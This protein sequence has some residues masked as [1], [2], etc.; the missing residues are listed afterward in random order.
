LFYVNEGPIDT[1][2]QIAG[3]PV[4]D[5]DLVSKQARDSFVENGW[6]QRSEGWNIIT[7]VGERAVHAL[8]LCRTRVNIERLPT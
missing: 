4:R 2:L 3:S 1:L 7:K 6:V 8:A 5:G